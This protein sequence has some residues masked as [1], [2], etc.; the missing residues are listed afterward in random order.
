MYA[1]YVDAKAG[2]AIQA[3]A[4]TASI[5]GNFIRRAVLARTISFPNAAGGL[6]LPADL[7]FSL[8]LNIGE[9]VDQIDLGSFLRRQHRLQFADCRLRTNRR[10]RGICLRCRT[11]SQPLR[12]RA[13]AVAEQVS[14]Q[15]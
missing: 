15:H 12:E 3:I 2:R 14:D 4:I 1:A 6:L 9:L 13:A 10:D 8:M 7:E 11:R 5:S